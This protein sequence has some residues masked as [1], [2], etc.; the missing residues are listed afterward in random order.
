MGVSILHRAGVGWK[1]TN[2]ERSLK[3]DWIVL[4]FP[5]LPLCLFSP[6]RLCDPIAS[7]TPLSMGFPRQ[8]YWSGVPFPLPQDLPDPEIEPSS[9][10]SLELA[11]GFFT[12]SPTWKAPIPLIKN[13]QISTPPPF[14]HSFVVSVRRAGKGCLEPRS[15]IG[16]ACLVWNAS[17]DSTSSP[18]S[19]L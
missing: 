8:K 4:L 19:S 9:L 3:H 12:N 5:S 18:L 11:G 6:A 15:V 10:G 17:G 13:S 14:Y 7:R 1:F 2:N 16:N